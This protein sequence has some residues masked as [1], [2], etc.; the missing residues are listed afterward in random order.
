MR[1][2]ARTLFSFIGLSV[3]LSSSSLQA[4]DACSGWNDCTDGDAACDCIGDFERCSGCPSIWNAYVGAVF[5]KRDR[6]DAG[7]IIGPNPPNG[8]SF[9]RGSNF[10]FNTQEGIDVVVARRFANGDQIEGRYFGID[11]STATHR[12]TSGGNFIGAGFVGP[13]GSRFDGRYTSNLKSAE[14]NWRQPLSDQLTFLAGFRYIE[15]EDTLYYTINTS[16]A[17]GL[18]ENDNQLYGGQIGADLA[19][20]DHRRPFQLHVIGKAG[21][22]G[23]NADG[24]FRT[25]VGG[26]N[27]IGDFG[28]DES[29]SALAGDLQLVGSYPLTRHIAARGGYQMLWIDNVT[30]AGDNASVSQI[31]PVLLNNSLDYDG[32]VFY[33]GAMIGLEMMW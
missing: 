2:I 29:G 13:A 4:N 25:F 15:L 26:V 23:N 9:S 27:Q 18:Y 5:L 7:V 19:L 30:L 12:F 8:N 16:V 33:H 24:R 6:P 31:N 10:D 20:L 32:H 21:A 14:L 28:R 22:F 11:D 3:V 1:G 17:S